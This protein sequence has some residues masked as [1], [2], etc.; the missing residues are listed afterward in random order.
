MT[1]DSWDVE[2]EAYVCV[3]FEKNAHREGWFSEAVLKKYTPP[4]PPQIIMRKLIPS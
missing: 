4:P 3:W 2:R 1:V